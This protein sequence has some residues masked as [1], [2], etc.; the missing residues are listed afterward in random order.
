MS[1]P[2]G[3]AMN[4]AARGILISSFSTE[5][6][7]D[8]DEDQDRERLAR[9]AALMLEEARSWAYAHDFSGSRKDM[10]IKGDRYELLQVYQALF[11]GRSYTQLMA[12]EDNLARFFRF[13]RDRKQI[14]D[15]LRSLR[16]L[17][18][19]RP[20]T[21]QARDRVLAVCD[22]AQPLIRNLSAAAHHWEMS[23]DDD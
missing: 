19:G 20:I 22:L 14:V 18:R 13:T 21:V 1:S 6:R 12:D 23:Q 5:L 16:R 17:Q 2:Y 10:R 7:G 11:S 3:D 15:V 4:L 9:F 8:E